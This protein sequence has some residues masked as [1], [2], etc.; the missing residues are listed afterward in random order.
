MNPGWYLVS[1]F[2]NLLVIAVLVGAADKMLKLEIE[3]HKRLG[4]FFIFVL[5]IALEIASFLVA[6]RPFLLNFS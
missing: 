5:P 6:G 1:W 3:G 4:A 2:L